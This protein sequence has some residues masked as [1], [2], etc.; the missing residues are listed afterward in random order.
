MSSATERFRKRNEDWKERANSVVDSV[1][2]EILSRMLYVDPFNHFALRLSGAALALILLLSPA[3]IGQQKRFSSKYVK[4]QSEG[5]F[6]TKGPGKYDLDALVL[7]SDNKP[8]E[9]KANDPDAPTIPGYYPPTQQSA[10]RL[11]GSRSLVRRSISRLGRY[12]V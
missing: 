2:R 7:S 4:P 11:R 10:L 1:G 5:L 9:Q 3:A 6:Y 12:S 8:I